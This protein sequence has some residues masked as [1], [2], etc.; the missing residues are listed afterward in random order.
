MNLL[1]QSIHDVS[2][3]TAATRGVSE[4]ARRLLRGGED[5]A[6][7]FGRAYAAFLRELAEEQ[8]V[9]PHAS[10]PADPTPPQRATSGWVQVENPQ[11]DPEEARKAREAI[12]QA[13]REAFG[14]DPESDTEPMQFN[15]AL[16]NRVLTRRI[17]DA[18]KAQGLKQK[19]LARA[20]GM[21]E[22]QLSRMLRKPERASAITLARIATHLGLP[23]SR[24]L[25][26]L[27]AAAATSSSAS[28][29]SAA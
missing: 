17:R 14:K 24:L 9:K 11:I 8:P 6:E 21:D 27:E 3:Q 26:G 20:I 29:S 12:D 16:I 7:S 10:P 1:N 23:A 4:H 15:D 28:S 19:D 18:L 13:Y 2:E 5:L 25:E 22:G